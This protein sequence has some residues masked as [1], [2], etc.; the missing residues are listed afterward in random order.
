MRRVTPRS[1]SV[2]VAVS[3][4]AS[5][6]LVIWD[7]VISAGTG[8]GVMVPAAPALFAATRSTIRI[9][10]KLHIVV[11]TVDIAPPATPFLP[12]KLYSNNLEFAA[13]AGVSDL[14]SLEL[15]VDQFPTPGSPAPHLALGYL[16]GVLPSFVLAPL[17]VEKR[18]LVHTSCRKAHGFG[19]DS[20]AAIDG[21]I[22]SAVNANDPDQRPHQLFL[23][24]D[25]IYADEVPTLLM[26]A[27]NQIGAELLGAQ[28][29]LA[30]KDGN[31]TVVEI[32]ATLAN[33]PATRRER[34]VVRTRSSPPTLPSTI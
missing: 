25:Q 23:T 26:P 5:V 1:A 13:A 32:A 8:P 6:T 10:G 34:I 30:A 14:K 7:R 12:G 4:S 17:T 18:N 16:P 21:M 27:I 28:E 15:L 22:R 24:G 31:N 11:V 33:F 3:E 20:L 2:W 9:G 19:K 29:S